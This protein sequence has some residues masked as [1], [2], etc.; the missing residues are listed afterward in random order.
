M[1]NK[2]EYIK[3]KIEYMKNKIEYMKNKI[4]YMKNKIEYI[5]KL[6]PNN[7]LDFYGILF[8]S[9]WLLESCDC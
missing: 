9:D 6:K 3:N 7:M 2:I 5:L 8:D 4:E 1:K